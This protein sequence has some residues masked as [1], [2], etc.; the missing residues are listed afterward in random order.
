MICTDPPVALCDY[1]AARA[2]PLFRDLLRKF[3]V[4]YSGDLESLM[5]YSQTHKPAVVAL[6][7]N[8]PTRSSANGRVSHSAVRQFLRSHGQKLTILLYADTSRLSLETYSHLLS[9]GAQQ[10]LD[11]RSPRFR[12]DLQ[13][14]LLR[15][16]RLQLAESAEHQQL[17]AVFARY[18][19]V[20]ISIVLATVKAFVTPFPTNPPKQFDRVDNRER[21]SRIPFICPG[22]LSSQSLHFRKSASK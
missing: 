14:E 20:G 11:E 19:L 18:G 5:H 7:L 16:V 10:I 9:E 13:R 12:V 22:P 17:R 3:V 8:W 15:Q 2:V 1:H 4:R 21:V 6:P